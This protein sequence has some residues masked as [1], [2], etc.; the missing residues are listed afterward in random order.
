MSSPSSEPVA[1][2]T[3][4]T[5][6]LGRHVALGLARA[7][8]R[9][10][11]IARNAERGEAARAWLTHQAPT[12]EV[13]LEYADLSLLAAT[14]D[15]GERIAARHPQ[16]ALL[17]AN[18]GVFRAKPL[19]TAEGLDQVLAV[20]LLSPL[21]LAE[22]LVPALKAGA[23]AR[24]VMTGSSSSDRA[25]LAP[26]QLVL[27]ERWGMVRAYGQSKLALLM[28]TIALAERLEGSGVSAN[29]VHP[30]FVATPLVR[31]PG[32]IG[33]A[34]ALLGRFGLSEAEGADSP[35]HVALDPEFAVRSGAYVKKRRP[36][37]PNPQALDRDQCR[38]VLAEAERLAASVLG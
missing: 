33:A 12:A 16:I 18:A 29:V 25:N 2:V 23:P 24:I 3:G 6:G 1:V 22:T 27:G 35:L 17:M 32:A 5:S 15:A 34:W 19:A 8:R 13:E 21:V 10:V 20:N 38:R 14:R 36:V 9:L 28:A 26:D 30:G 4:A 37:R 31:E 7:G 11:L